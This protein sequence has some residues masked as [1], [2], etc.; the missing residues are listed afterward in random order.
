MLAFISKHSSLLLMLA[1]VFGFL[2]PNA[3]K[4]L[5]PYLPFILFFLM[6]FTLLGI[7]QQILIKKLAERQIWGYAFFH[8][9]GYHSSAAHLQRYWVQITHYY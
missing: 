8:A 2:L 4:A 6:L 5:F 9:A 7:Q 1:A 3:S